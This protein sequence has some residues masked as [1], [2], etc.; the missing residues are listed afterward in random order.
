MR[1]L[2]RGPTSE[3]AAPSYAAQQKSPPVEGPVSGAAPLAA[4]PNLRVRM[5]RFLQAPCARADPFVRHTCA[6]T[7]RVASV[8]SCHSRALRG[9]FISLYRYHS[10]SRYTF[11]SRDSNPSFT[12]SVFAA[13]RS[14]RLDK[15]TTRSEERR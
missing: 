13:T 3:S 6:N 1:R 11:V 14:A 12:Y 8:R 2:Y 4:G 9:A 5:T 15:V 7:S 10:S